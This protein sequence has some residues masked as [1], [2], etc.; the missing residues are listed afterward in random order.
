M[1]LTCIYRANFLYDEHFRCQISLG[2]IYEKLNSFDDALQCYEQALDTGKMVK[3]KVKQVDALICLGLITMKQSNV[4]KARKFFKKAFLLGTPVDD[5]RQKVARLLKISSLIR[6][7]LVCLEQNV[8]CPEK[9]MLVCDRLG[10]HFVEI[11]CFDLAINYY[12]KE[13]FY[14]T[15]TNQADSVLA[16]I[17]VSIGQTYLDDGN[18]VEAINYFQH[19]YNFNFGNKCEQCKS[20]L[21]IADIQECLCSNIDELELEERAAMRKEIVSTYN[22]A[23]NLFDFK[24]LIR[25]DSTESSQMKCNELK[26]YVQAAKNYLNFLE[27]NHLDSNQQEVLQ[28]NLSKLNVTDNEEIEDEIDVDSEDLYESYN[29]DLLSSDSDRSFAENEDEEIPENFQSRPRRSGKSS[30]VTNRLNQFG[31]TPL[32]TA[33]ISGNISQVERLIEQKANINAKDYCGWTPLHEACNH[34]Y[35]E[36]VDCLIRN[37]ANMQSCD[38]R[39]DRITALHDACNCGHFSIIRLLLKHGASVLALTTHN[40]TPLEC[41]M[42]WRQRTVTELTSN[43]LNECLQLEDRIKQEMKEK[44]FDLNRLGNVYS[45]TRN[46]TTTNKL[47]RNLLDTD[48]Y[49]TAN[50]LGRSSDENDDKKLDYENPTFTRKEYQNAI[51]SFRRNRLTSNRGFNGGG[52]GSGAA[53]GGRA[54]KSALISDNVVRDDWLIDDLGKSRNNSRKRDKDDHLY[55]DTKKMRTSSLEEDIFPDNYL[56]EDDYVSEFFGSPN[57]HPI[58]IDDDQDDVQIV[59]RKRNE[60]RTLQTTIEPVESEA[61]EKQQKRNNVASESTTSINNEVVIEKIDDFTTK[62][63]TVYFDDVE[64]STFGVPIKDV[65][66]NCKSLIDEVCKRYFHKYGIK[67]IISLKTLDGASLSDDDLITSNIGVNESVNATISSWI[68]EPADQRYNELCMVNELEMDETIESCLKLVNISG[69]F[70]IT[71]SFI[72]SNRH[73]QILFQTLFR[74]EIKELVCISV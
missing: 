43:E 48:I 58:S 55:G 29:L 6:D 60:P 32:H 62:V 28:D 25:N 51:Q 53:G 35:L 40:E 73:I 14:A 8:N 50:R 2:S 36:I 23:L 68:I 34:G 31:E 49:S 30:K 71:N 39:S 42:N 13:L 10:D 12:K 37:G 15:E 44:G 45:K 24:S 7:D 65:T 19:E 21:K 74:Q 70:K 41:L 46:E 64:R 33:C 5:D 17:Y 72:S 67:P 20:L 4:H 54:T 38:E 57:K 27:A 66:V 9:S 56:N 11:K 1:L 69:L 61:Q 47:R 22:D 52:G 18:Y 16:N 63:A 59:S 26:L 3:S